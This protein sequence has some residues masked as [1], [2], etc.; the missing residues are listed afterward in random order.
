M[1]QIR[2]IDF[3]NKIVFNFLKAVVARIS[4][5]GVAVELPRYGDASIVFP[6]K[7]TQLKQ[8]SPVTV[9]LRPQHF[10]AK[11]ALK[12]KLNIELVEHLGGESFPRLGELGGFRVRGHNRGHQFDADDRNR[13]RPEPGDGSASIVTT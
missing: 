9:G 5:A 4:K 13:G 1:C 10:A 7:S 2:N 3:I 8:G 11:G 12:F 6:V